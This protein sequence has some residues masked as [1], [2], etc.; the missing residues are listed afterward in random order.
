M[1]I[2]KSYKNIL[3]S[4]SGSRFKIPAIISLSVM[5]VNAIREGRLS[6]ADL[7]LGSKELP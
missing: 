1:T 2:I 6:I 5:L 4:I 7:R 3:N